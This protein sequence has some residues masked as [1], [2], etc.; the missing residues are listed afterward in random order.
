MRREAFLLQLV[1]GILANPGWT[2]N[3]RA[4]VLSRE[5]HRAIADNSVTTRVDSNLVLL[6]VSV[7]DRWDRPVIGVPREIRIYD[8]NAG[9][10]IRQFASEDTPVSIALVFDASGS[11]E[12]TLEK[13]RAALGEFVKESNPDDEFLL[14]DVHEHPRVLVPFTRDPGEIQNRLPLLKSIAGVDELASVAVKIGTA[15]RNHY[16][17]GYA[18]SA[19]SLDGKID[20]IIQLEQ[21]HGADTWRATFR[22]S[23]VA[24]G[25]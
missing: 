5:P 20:R 4:S 21:P 10:K 1:W 23:Y 14:I 6:P 11:M 15:L 2:Q 7:W 9:Q 12:E 17:L 8:G 3:A 22:S 13:A 18:L 24:F 25:H 16:V 19:R